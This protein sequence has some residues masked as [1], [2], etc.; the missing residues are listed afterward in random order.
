MPQLQ[1]S[2]ITVSH[3][4]NINPQICCVLPE[5]LP[6]LIIPGSSVQCLY[7]TSS[8]AHNVVILYSY[9]GESKE[10][11]A[12]I[13]ANGLKLIPSFAKIGHLVKEINEGTRR[14]TGATQISQPKFLSLGK[15]CSRLN[16][17]ILPAVLSACE[18][19]CRT[20]K[21]NHMGGLRYLKTACREE[22]VDLR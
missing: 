7:V 12:A 1:I 2:R 5:N 9:F 18:T 8:C 17:I 6:L 10:Y 16:I 4:T 20:P 22:H 14:R 3:S 13:P 15:A 11:D 21:E 19:L